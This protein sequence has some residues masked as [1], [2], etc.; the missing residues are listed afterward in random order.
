VAQIVWG[1]WQRDHITVAHH[2]QPEDFDEAWHDPFRKD[3]EEKVH[4][5][6]GPYTKSVGIARGRSLIMVWRWQKGTEEEVWPITAYFPGKKKAV[7]KKRRK[8]RN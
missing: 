2:V 8:G 6:R 4:S 7:R 1:E 5:L 3:L